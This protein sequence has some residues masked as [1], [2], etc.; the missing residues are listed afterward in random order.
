[1]PLG[2]KKLLNKLQEK[3]WISNFTIGIFEILKNV[4]ATAFKS[5]KNLK[6]RKSCQKRLLYLSIKQ[7]ITIEIVINFLSRETFK[8]ASVEF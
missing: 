6:I 2:D 5:H 4:V 8:N 3:V 1:M 7:L